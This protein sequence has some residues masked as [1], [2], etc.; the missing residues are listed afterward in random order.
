MSKMFGLHLLEGRKGGRGEKGGQRA[1]ALVCL[2]SEEGQVDEEAEG[3]EVEEEGRLRL[4][5]LSFFPPSHSPSL[6]KSISCRVF[7][8]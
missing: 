4:F 1:V 7:C 8:W 5:S 6:S 2:Q 3:E